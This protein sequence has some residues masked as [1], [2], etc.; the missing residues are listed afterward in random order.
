MGYETAFLDIYDD[1]GGL[2][3]D[4]VPEMSALPGFVKT[5]ASVTQDSPSNLFALVM[6]ENGRPLK[7][8]ATADAGNTWL[9]ALYFAKTRHLLPEDAQKV[10]AANLTAAC[11]HYG[12]ELP[13]DVRLDDASLA[14]NN[15]VDVD[16]KRP[17]MRKVASEQEDVEYAIE[18]ADGTKHYPLGNA[19]AVVAADKYFSRSVGQFTPRQRREYAVK[20]AS[21]ADK[22]ALP[23]SDEIRK[24]AGE[25]YSPR[26]EGHLGIRYHHLMSADSPSEFRHALVKLAR[27][28]SSLEP[29]RFAEA[30]HTFDT[31]SGLDRLWDS[32]I[33]D[34]WLST[35]GMTKEAKGAAPSQATFHVGADSVT[36]EALAILAKKRGQVAEHFGSSMAD[37][38]AKDPVAIFKSMPDPQKRVLANMANSAQSSA[39]H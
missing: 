24:Y 31:A 39:L 6:L 21:V 20:V 29:S 11:D 13:E 36:A 38:F 19:E 17:P 15:V 32:T 34:P 9:S 22:H 7:K 28:Q 26:L 35:F 30:L 33:A 16:G 27:A 8:F 14:S 4:I 25:G 37:S 5:A 18:R 12:I 23:V 1:Q 3:K 10:A 2:L